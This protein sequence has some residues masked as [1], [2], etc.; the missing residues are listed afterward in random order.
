MLFAVYGAW[1]KG[2]GI[3]SILRLNPFIL[4]CM[5]KRKNIGECRELFFQINGGTQHRLCAVCGKW[6]KWAVGD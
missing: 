4:R 6:I 3:I 2:R 1:S 5:T